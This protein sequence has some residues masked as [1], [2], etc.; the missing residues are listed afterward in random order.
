MICLGRVI[1]VIVGKRGLIA[2]AVII[3]EKAVI[4]GLLFHYLLSTIAISITCRWFI[5]ISELG[6]VSV[7][8]LRVGMSFILIA[9]KVS[10]KL[11]KYLPIHTR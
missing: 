6:Y 11:T 7:K 10:Y 4:T 2:S 1:A 8:L 5:E 9:F 3:C